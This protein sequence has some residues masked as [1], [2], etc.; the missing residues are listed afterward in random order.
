MSNV[1]RSRKLETPIVFTGA[2]ALNEGVVDAFSE[3]LNQKI[4]IHQ[5]QK[6]SGAIGVAFLA[7]NRNTIGGF[8]GFRAETQFGSFSCR[9]PTVQNI[10]DIKENF[11]NV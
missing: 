10:K 1:C 6:I 8:Q 3:I 4:E 2:V 11:F 5:Y 7:L 9:V